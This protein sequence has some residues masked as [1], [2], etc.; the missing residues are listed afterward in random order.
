MGFW[1]P[2][3]LEKKLR[4]LR[5]AELRHLVLCI[6]ETRN[7]SDSELPAGARVVRFRRRINPTAVLAAIE[8]G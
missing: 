8:V 6:D 4:S 1:T 7:C 5:Q 2:A 3:Y